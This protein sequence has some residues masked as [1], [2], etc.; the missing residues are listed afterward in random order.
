MKAIEQLKKQYTVVSVID[1]IG[2][3]I[4]TIK[5]KQNEYSV[6]VFG[7]NGKCVWVTPQWYSRKRSADEAIKLLYELS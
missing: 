1:H 2:R 4:V 3:L 5:N 7:R 6:R